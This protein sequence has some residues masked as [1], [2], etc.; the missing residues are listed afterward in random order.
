MDVKAHDNVRFLTLSQRIA[1]VTMSIILVAA[2]ITETSLPTAW[3]LV[4]LAVAV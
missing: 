3:L 2:V 1:R 4:L